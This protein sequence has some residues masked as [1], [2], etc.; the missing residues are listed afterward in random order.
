MDYNKDR[1]ENPHEKGDFIPVD[2]GRV[3][4][5][6]ESFLLGLIFGPPCFLFGD[7]FFAHTVAVGQ[8]GKVHDFVVIVII[9][10]IVSAAAVTAAAAITGAG[11]GTIVF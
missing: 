3:L 10:A 2:K 1:Q 9:I 7:F 4:R 8:A 11:A 5:F 6:V